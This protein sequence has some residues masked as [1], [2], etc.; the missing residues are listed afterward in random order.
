VKE[1]FKGREN[2]FISWDAEKLRKVINCVSY[3]ILF[4]DRNL[5]EVSKLITL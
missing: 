1:T 4:V 3:G 5:K 2:K